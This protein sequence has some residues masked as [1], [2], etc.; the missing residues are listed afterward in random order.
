M[1]PYPSLPAVADA[2]DDPLG[3]G[4]AWLREYVEGQPLRFSVADSGLLAFADADR[5]LGEEPPLY[6]RPAIRT[7]REQFDRDAFRAAVDDPTA[8]TFHGVATCKERAGYDWADTPAFLGTVVSHDDRN[9]RLPVDVADRALDRL[10]LGAVPT[11][12]KELR[13][14]HFNHRRYEFPDSAFRETPVAGVEVHNRSGARGRLANPDA[15]DDRDPLDPTPE[16]VAGLV[17]D[18]RFA[19]VID[20][21]PEGVHADP[22]TATDRVLE[23]IARERRVDLYDGPGQFRPGTV[24]AA[25]GDRVRERLATLS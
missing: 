6:Y 3:T 10:G 4:H 7:V 21:H 5:R 23:A 24:R 8:V 14:R 16:G 15:P 19:R 20:A 11:V 1:H 25:V 2:P 22:A 18:D 9:G 17:T 12:E 13:T